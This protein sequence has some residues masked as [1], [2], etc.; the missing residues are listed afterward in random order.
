M[1]ELKHIRKQ[2]ENATPLKDV[3]AVINKGNVIAIIGPSG[4]GKSTL[5]R[6]INMLD[7]PTSGQIIIDGEDIT[8]DGYDLCKARKKVGMVFQSFNLFAHLTIIENIMKPQ[9]DLLN[10]D[11]QEAYDIAIDLLKTVGLA[12]VALQYPSQL[13]GGQKQRVAICRALAMNPEV[14]LFDEP[15]S[16]LDPTMVREVESVI[17]KLASEGRTM[18]IVTHEMRFAKEIANRVFYM[19]QGGIYEDGTPEQIFDNPT[20]ER[21]RA[22]IKQLKVLNIKIDDPNF[23][24]QHVVYQIEDYCIKSNINHKDSYKI[25]SCFEELCKT[26][27]IPH[28]NNDVHILVCIEYSDIEKNMTMS[29]KFNGEFFDPMQTKDELALAVLKNSAKSLNTSPIEDELYKNEVK[30]IFK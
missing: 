23:D 10:R 15:T 6:G 4:T 13:S 12:R 28:L 26:I 11:K 7:K 16:A 1:I 22:F 30:V 3:N 9:I 20:K 5:L 8:A 25:Q 29:V 2:Y 27:L 19:D 14:I 18:M 21:T 17:K 24:F